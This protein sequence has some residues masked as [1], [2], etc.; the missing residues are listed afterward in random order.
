MP[1]INSP[2]YSTLLLILSTSHITN[3]VK[4]LIEG[5]AGFVLFFKIF[6]Y[7]RESA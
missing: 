1:F 6:I 2:L 3:T 7:L 4:R 5:E